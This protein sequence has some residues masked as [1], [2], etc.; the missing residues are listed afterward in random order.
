MDY[1]QMQTWLESLLP[2]RPA[3]LER[4]EE[5]ARLHHFP[6]IGALNGQLCYVLTRLH[7]A[8]RVFELGSGYGYSTAWFARAVAENVADQSHSPAAASQLPAEVHH[9]VWDEELSAQARTHLAA[10]GHSELVQFH[11]GEAVATLQGIDGLFDLIFLDITKRDYPAAIAPI[12]S[13]LRPG[14]VLLADNML[15][16]GRPWDGS[17]HDE[18]T[19]AIRHVAAYLS[20]SP[21]WATTIV[22][23]RDGMLVARFNG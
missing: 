19:T 16:R 3:E 9:C 20:N 17:L 18:G 23:L 11:V 15:Y 2:A 14:G 4:M 22:P 7:D 21:R 6:I 5:H 10:L 1:V 12:E 8:R 13:H